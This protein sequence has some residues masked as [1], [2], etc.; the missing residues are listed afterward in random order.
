MELWWVCLAVGLLCGPGFSAALGRHRRQSDTWRSYQLGRGQSS[1]QL[2]SPRRN[3]LPQFVAGVGSLRAAQPVS[4]WGSRNLGGFQPRQFVQP[5]QS[6]SSPISLQCNEDSMVVMVNRDFYGN[7]K[8]VKP[9]DLNLG[10]CASGSQ[11]TN[12]M[13]I[14]N[15]GLEQCGN[16]L[17]M[18][19]DWLIYQAILS[20]TPTASRGVPII[21][22]NSA[23]V[24]IQCFYP[25]HGNVSSNPI[26]PTWI[27]FSTTVTSEERLAF[28][29]R[30]MTPDWSAP[31]SFLV[32]QLGDL[33]YIEAFLDIQNH[34]PMMLFVD[35]CVASLTPD[36]TSGPSYDIISNNG[37]LMDGAQEDSASVFV[38]PRP[39]PNI[40]RFMIDAFLFIDSDTS[41]IFITC[42][43]RAAPINQTPDSMNKACSYNKASSSW[44]PVE[45]QSGI[46][47]CC[48][49]GNCAAGQGMSRISPPGRPRGFGKRDVGSREEKHG[50][51]VLG[52]LLVSGAKPNKG[53]RVGVAQASR[54]S[55]GQGSPQ[56]WVLIAIGSVSAVVVAIGLSM[57]GKCILK[58]FSSKESV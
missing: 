50:L 40:L 51:A 15:N 38:S 26:K 2:G 44:S 29:L 58:R 14:F 9:S 56:L 7:G 52:P 24:P 13:V 1:S 32:F 28:S 8:L 27:P 18:T 19:P 16:T 36:I 21:R 30:L 25:R 4:G 57:V 41:K 3:L 47:Q 46:C 55:A 31:S 20:Y 11:T 48:S 12:A 43:L 42:S 17:E 10:T 49:T 53:S 22:T 37:C 6:P 34:E 35:S 45:G 39:Q 54:M 5:V 33:F 23:V